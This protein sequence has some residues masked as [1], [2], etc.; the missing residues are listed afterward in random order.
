M[1]IYEFISAAQ[2]FPYKNTVLKQIFLS[3]YWFIQDIYTILLSVDVNLSYFA[4]SIMVF[5]PFIFSP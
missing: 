5:I 2:I 4:S 3:F 1:R